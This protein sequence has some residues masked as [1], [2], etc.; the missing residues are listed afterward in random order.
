MICKAC[1]KDFHYCPSCEYIDECEAGYCSFKC[2]NGTS[3][4]RKNQL[5]SWIEYGAT[6]ETVERLYK[7]FVRKVGGR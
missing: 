1:G 6:E 4:W 7:E 2:Y 3:S 5:I